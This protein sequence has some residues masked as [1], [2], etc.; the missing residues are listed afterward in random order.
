MSKLFTTI[1][2][3]FIGA[4]TLSAQSSDKVEHPFNVSVQGGALVSLNENAF[5]YR[6]NGK[7]LNLISPQGSIAIGYDF[8]YRWGMR[9]SASYGKNAS[10]CNT[11]ETSGHGFY[12]YTFK[13]VNVFADAVLDLG[14]KDSFFSPKLY[15]GLGGAH[16]FGFTDAGHP[17]QEVSKKNTV[18]GFRGG[19]IAQFDIT[20]HFG[21]FIDLCGEAYTD[22]YNGLL[23][24]EKNQKEVSGYAGF[25][26]DLRGLA[27]LGVILHF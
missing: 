11:V 14:K 4:L 9:I 10:A 16:T 23:P 8:S 6:D 13:S 26:L 7:A 27:S 25:P 17:W 19:F 20:S 12:P 3:L 15:A 24:N 21:M 22:K 5:S 18:F 1:S 2:A